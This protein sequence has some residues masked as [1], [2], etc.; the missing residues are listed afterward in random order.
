MSDDDKKRTLLNIVHDATDP[1]EDD[2]GLNEAA[3]SQQAERARLLGLADDAPLLPLGRDADG[4]GFY[5]LNCMNIAVRYSETDHG[6]N[7]FVAMCGDDAWLVAN[8][9][10]EKVVPLKDD[11]GKK[12]GET[13]ITTGFHS[14]NV[15]TAFMRACTRAGIWDPAERLRGRGAW[16]GPNGSLILHLGSRLIHAQPLG[17]AHAA[18]LTTLPAGIYDEHIYPAGQPLPGPADAPH[19]AE[20]DDGCSDGGP[21]LDVLDLLKTWNWERADVDAYLAFCWVGTAMICGALPKRPAI[22][23]TGDRGTGKSTLQDVF[24]LLIGPGLIATKDTTAAGLYQRLGQSALP[25]LIDEQERGE[26]DQRMRQIMRLM[27]TAYDGDLMLRGGADHK[28]VEFQCRSSFLVAAINIPDM[29]DAEMS[30]SAV[31]SLNRLK[32]EAPFALD[33]AALKAAGRLMLR[34]LVDGWQRF[35]LAFDLYAKALMEKAG[36]DAR[37]ADQLGILLAAGHVMLHDDLPDDAMLAEWAGRLEAAAWREAMELESDAQRCLA[38]LLASRPDRWASGSKQTVGHLVRQFAKPQSSEQDR[39]DAN[40]TLK[41]A[42]L[43][44]TMRDGDPLIYLAVRK[45]HPDLAAIFEGTDWGGRGG[46]KGGWGSSLA[47]IDGAVKTHGV[48]FDGAVA[49]CVLIPTQAIFGTEDGL[50]L[51]DEPA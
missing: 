22:V 37:G 47:R 34:R 33:D 27:R 48:R 4:K 35:G 45:T 20:A 13:T 38:H 9:P 5:Y 40:D 50:P 14:G 6:H 51:M 31:L 17:R 10:Q 16:T 26:N 7:Q 46:Y 11:D 12:I 43:R 15:R 32:H 49:K 42:G 8:Y 2:G 3:W 24:K 1:D 28:G 39:R 44:M 18:R 19:P 41:A 30:R 25:V 36:H 23:L 29:T 21:L